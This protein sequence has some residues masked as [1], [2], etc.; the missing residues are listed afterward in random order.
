MVKRNEMEERETNKTHRLQLVFELL[1]F[2]VFFFLIGSLRKYG[3]SS[4]T[5]QLVKSLLLRACLVFNWIAV[6]VVSTLWVVEI[7]RFVSIAGSSNACNKSSQM[8]HNDILKSQPCKQLV[9][10][11]EWLMMVLPV[12]HYKDQLCSIT[13][14]TA[15]RIEILLSNSL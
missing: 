3:T 11:S 6:T 2:L 13:L 15:I 12:W 8:E 10:H 5:Q 1:F 7:Y 9:N 14:S 4:R